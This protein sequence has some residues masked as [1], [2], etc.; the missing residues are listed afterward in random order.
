MYVDIQILEKYEIKARP[1]L[2]YNAYDGIKIGPSI[3]GDY[4]KNIM[5]LK[6]FLINT[7][8]S[9]KDELTMVLTI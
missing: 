6:L 4:L 9:R 1:D 2:W 8:I 5:S 3:K 7:G